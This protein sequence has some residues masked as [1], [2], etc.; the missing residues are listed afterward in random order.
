GRQG[1]EGGALFGRLS[2]GSEA[3]N[4]EEVERK[5]AEDRFPGQSRGVWQP[6]GPYRA[7]G[8][9]SEMCTQ[10]RHSF[11][12]GTGTVRETCSSSHCHDP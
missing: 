8:S 1:P 9:G 6:T 3:P 2:L 10:T 4:N 7:V 5:K 11:D 12:A